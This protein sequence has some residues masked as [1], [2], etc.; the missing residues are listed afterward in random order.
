MCTFI[1][2]ATLIPVLEVDT[3]M[4]GESLKAYPLT[5]YTLYK[6]LLNVCLPGLESVDISKQ[7]LGIQTYRVTDTQSVV[8]HFQSRYEVDPVLIPKLRIVNYQP[9][10]NGWLSYY[11]IKPRICV[12][13]LG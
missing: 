9:V 2:Q 12:N 7:L 10:A 6:Q 8:R 13:Q 1:A 3:I 5:H 11:Q 4:T